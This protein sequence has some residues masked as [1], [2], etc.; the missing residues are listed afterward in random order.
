MKKLIVL[1]VL[2]GILYVFFEV[3]FGA[4]SKLFAGEFQLVGASSLYMLIVGGFLGVTLGIFNTSNWV[5]KTFNVFVQSLIGA[6][7]IT[8]I[9]FISGCILNIGLGFNLWNYSMFSL[10]LCGQVCLPFSI[11]W[12]LICPFIFWCDDALRFFLYKEGSYYN[13]L[14]VYK[15]LFCFW[16]STNHQTMLL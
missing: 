2:M 1:F 15:D 9:E 13:L 11:I 10:N 8:L 4:F 7:L 14:A 16:K 6:V 3:A 12:F 5:R